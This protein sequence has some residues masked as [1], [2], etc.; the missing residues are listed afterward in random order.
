MASQHVA[1][2]AQRVSRLELRVGEPDTTGLTILRDGVELPSAQW[3]EAVPLDGGQVHLVARAPGR[4]EWSST[5][6]VAP[7]GAVEVITVPALRLPETSQ[8]EAVSARLATEAVEPPRRSLVLP[9]SLGAAAL[10]LGGVAIAVD[11]SARGLASDAEAAAQAGDL[12][13]AR[14]LN[15]RANSRRDLAQGLGVVA[16]LTAGAAVVTYF[17]GRRAAT[18]TARAPQVTPLWASGVAG[19][20]G[21]ALR[22]GW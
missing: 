11:V 18:R 14:R 9:L 16:G 20:T 13:D 12:P 22:G 3:G 7:E 21:V 17:V 10:A 6:Q 5:V 8:A 15:E 4:M 1:A 19:F 2:L